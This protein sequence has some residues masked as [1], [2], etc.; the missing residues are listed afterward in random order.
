MNKSQLV[1]KLAEEAL[2]PSKQAEQVV[3]IFFD[4]IA[5]GLVREGRSELR[6]LGSFKVKEY[7]G[8]VGRN[9]KSGEPINVPPKKLPFFKVSRELKAMV[10][11][12]E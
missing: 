6:G 1:E 8:Y 7:A 5:N 4:S 12:E 9:P 11:F 10:D 2:L 3:D